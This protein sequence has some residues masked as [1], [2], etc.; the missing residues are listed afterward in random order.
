MRARSLSTANARGPKCLIYVPR[1]REALRTMNQ[2]NGTGDLDARDAVCL[3]YAR[4]RI[5]GRS[6]AGPE[7]PRVP[8]SDNVI[9]VR[10]ARD[11]CS[12]CF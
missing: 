5:K 11:A 12:S 8:L 3:F 9:G 1:L 10:V 6:S 7:G 4:A 2:T